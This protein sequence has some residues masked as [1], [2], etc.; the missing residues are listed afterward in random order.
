MA[1]PDYTELIVFEGAVSFT[2]LST[3]QAMTVTSG[4][5]LLISRDG[6]FQGPSPATRQEMQDAKDSTN[7]PLTVAQRKDQKPPLVPILISIDAPLAV[8]GIGL[9]LSARESVPLLLLSDS[10]T[11][12]YYLVCVALMQERRR[13]GERP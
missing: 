10:T 1:T 12:S 3:G 8:T 2:A 9:G 7:I 5:K 6:P 4:M 11:L 13:R